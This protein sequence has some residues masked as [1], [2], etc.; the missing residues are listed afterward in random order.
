M[1][2][3]HGDSPQ[4]GAHRGDPPRGG[5]RG[6][7]HHSLHS[8]RGK[9]FFYPLWPFLKQKL[10]NKLSIFSKSGPFEF[11]YPFDVTYERVTSVH[12]VQLEA[13][14]T[15]R[16]LM[17]RHIGPAVIHHVSTSHSRAVDVTQLCQM[18]WRDWS[19]V[20]TGTSP[21][22]FLPSLPLLS[23]RRWSE[24][25]SP[26]AAADSRHPAPILLVFS[27]GCSRVSIA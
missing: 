24:V 23:L 11:V 8:S 4:D 21:F 13:M 5:H 26:F 27:E 1:A 17:W 9:E 7:W 15:A 14:R 2:R 3:R 25:A 10:R 16:P 12:M 22:F 20:L 6:T 18:H 19:A